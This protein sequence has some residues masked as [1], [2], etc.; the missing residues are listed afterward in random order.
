MTIS[1]VVTGRVTNEDGEAMIRVQ[2]VALRGPS[3]DEIE[4]KASFTS[5]KRY[6]RAVSSAQTDDRGQYRIFGLKPGEY[7]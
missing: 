5:R 6:L 7:S 1:G 3:E 4:D 2:V